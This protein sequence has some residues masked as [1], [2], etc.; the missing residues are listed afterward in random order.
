MGGAFE[1]RT[2]YGLLLAVGLFVAMLG[3]TAI[4]RR[5]GRPRRGD[6]PEGVRAGAGAIEG[7]VF[8]LLGLLV[9][10]TFSGAATRFDARRALVVEEAN[11]IGTAWL[12]LDLLPSE[13]Q[14]A[15]RDAFRRYLDSR[16]ESY[17]HLRRDPAAARAAYGRSQALQQEIWSRS[18]EATRAAPGPAAML[19]LPALN[20]MLDIATTRMTTLR[21]HPPYTI[22]ALLVTMAI[23]SALLAGYA[24]G[25]GGASGR[26]YRIAFAG[27]VALAVYVIVDLEYPRL[28][29]IRVDDADQVLVDL[30]AQMDAP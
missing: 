7:A 6:D 27:F 5:M 29:W 12:R 3:A 30:R 1:I 10:F 23:A 9:A 16:L 28:G 21:F 22:F 25:Q 18:V 24:M 11:A 8:A 20:Q 14:P 19:L 17:A 2:L 15:L 26:I 13:A 4:G